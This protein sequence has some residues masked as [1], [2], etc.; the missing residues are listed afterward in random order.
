M[1]DEVPAKLSSALEADAE[2]GDGDDEE[3]YSRD[4]LY[5]YTQQTTNTNPIG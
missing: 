5:T 3:Q 2:G 4:G 1:S